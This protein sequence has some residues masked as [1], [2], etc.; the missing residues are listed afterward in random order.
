MRPGE[1]QDPLQSG[2]TLIRSSSGLSNVELDPGD[3]PGQAFNIGTLKGNNSQTFSNFVS[4]TDLNDY[5]RL[6]LS[7]PGSLSLELTGLSTKANLQL[8]NSSHTLIGNSAEL[9]N[10][11][12][13][14]NLSGL[15]AGTYYVDVHTSPSSGAT[16]YTLNLSTS[17]DS[18]SSELIANATTSSINAATP[19]VS[20]DASS[21]LATNFS[22]IDASGDSTAYTVFQGGAIR[23]SYGFQ[24]VASLS[25][26]RLEALS[27][28]SVVST[29]GTW[30]GASLSSALVNLASF[31]ALTAGNYQIRAVIQ[32][33]DGQEFLAATQS[34]SILSNTRING[35]FAADTL[36]YSAGLGN[37]A[38]ILGRG[39]TDTLNLG[40]AGVSAA[41][42]AS[43]NGLSLSAFNPL[44]GSTANQAIYGGTAFDYLTLTDGR[45]IYFQGIEFLRFAD[46]STLEL[47]VHPNDTYFGSQWNL[48]VSDVSSAWRYSQGTSNVLLVSLDTGLAV[49]SNGLVNTV[50]ISTN[51]LTSYYWPWANDDFNDYGHGQAAISI[52]AGTANNASGTAGINWNSPVYVNDVYGGNGLGWRLTL[53]SAIQNA[54]NYARTYNLKVVFQG[55]I[56]GDGWL[57]DGGTQAQ[58]EQLIQANSDIATFAIAAGNGGPG[59]NLSDPNYL[60]SVSGVAKLETTYSNVMSVGALQYQGTNVV[61]GITNATSVDLAAYSNRGSNLTLVAATDSPVMDKFG[62]FVYFN[63]TSAANPNLAGIAS[64]V[65]SVNSTLTGGQV[66]QILTDTAMDLGTL[67][68]DNTFGYGLVNADAAVRRAAA[69]Q[70]NAEVA[71]LYSGATLFV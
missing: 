54:I 24:N 58:L 2:N 39:G 45:E 18:E 41:N 5:Y 52:M 63:E 22:V 66:R 3:G 57:A 49:G 28:S 43:I 25:N 13:A 65:W 68:R 33:T 46:G 34:M 56:Q 60:T 6:D 40:A 14:I 20:T 59:G 71:N 61:N 55:G 19:G 29:L 30:S 9:D 48:A 62:N 15:T 53:Q 51:R 47:Q 31:S 67:G 50:D 16:N 12:E 32:T 37:G 11:T 21:V 4:S 10:L 64:L 8:F 69:L 1:L 7:S 26:V 17:L 44:S 36:N 38:I 35:T 23:V 27:S 70:R 42:I